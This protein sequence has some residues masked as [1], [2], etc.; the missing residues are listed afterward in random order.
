MWVAYYV[1]DT[2]IVTFGMTM[3]NL[4]FLQVG[5][6]SAVHF[7]AV[8]GDSATTYALIKAGANFDLKAKV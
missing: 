8:N 1:L 2:L 4:S 7:S 6:W 5:G 3:C